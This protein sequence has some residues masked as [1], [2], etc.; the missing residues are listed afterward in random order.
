M[1]PKF[2]ELVLPTYY[3]DVDFYLKDDLQQRTIE[4]LIEQNQYGEISFSYTPGL[5]K[6]NV[7]CGELIVNYKNDNSFVPL[8]KLLKNVHKTK[9]FD[10][11]I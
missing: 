4:M 7:Y 1:P 3:I 11:M 9:Y 2:A 6:N 8:K 10:G 5:M